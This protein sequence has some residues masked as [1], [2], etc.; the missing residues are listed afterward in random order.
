MI[1][2]NV[3]ETFAGIGSQRKALERVKKEKKDFD[4]EIVYTSEW[5]T[6][7]IIGYDA[8]HH[9]KTK[10]KK[11]DSI[12]MIKY[13]ENFIFSKDSKNPINNITDQ[14]K[15]NTDYFQRL[16][17]ANQRNK[18]LG[19]ITS[20]KGN[21]LKEKIDLITY[22][23]PCQDLSIAG[24]GV[25]IS[26]ETN[27]R[28]SLLWNIR[29]ILGEM[30]SQDKLPRYLLME[31]VTAIKHVK[32]IDN[33][34]TFKKELK[35][36]GYSS[37]EFIENAVDHGIP[38]QRKRFFMLSILNYPEKSKL[39]L[40][41]FYSNK[42]TRFSSFINWE[43][44]QLTQRWEKYVTAIENKIKS[45]GIQEP[46]KFKYK[47]LGVYPTFNQANI[48]HGIHEDNISTITFSGENSRIRVLNENENGDYEVRKLSGYDNL[49]LMG[50]DK[51]DYSS[52]IKANLSDEKIRG[53]AGNSIVVNV[54]ESIFKLIYEIEKE[55]VK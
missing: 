52:M 4:F 19:D 5:Y 30:S 37:F 33:L 24:K 34:N 8:I 6:D 41:K 43:N 49:M 12:Q 28:S 1:K 20:I 11:I 26:K 45:D 21:Y 31:N 46:L 55:R 48:V 35:D 23:F 13:F 36:L 27:S 47:N 54:L 14:I 32:H 39:S 2:I 42:K 51:K 15:R 17:N 40:E 38:Q 16:Y 25:G 18:N 22:S 50:F 44:M 7:A 10:D 29:R 9:K 53:F 3:F